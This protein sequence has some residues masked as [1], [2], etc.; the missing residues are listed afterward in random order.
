MITKRV[1]S[2]YG[3]NTIDDMSAGKVEAIKITCEDML[4]VIGI[5]CAWIM[6]VIVEVDKM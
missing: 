6:K 2:P 3:A 5:T 1:V 4:V